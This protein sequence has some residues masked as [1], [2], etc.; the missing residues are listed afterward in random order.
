MCRAIPLCSPGTEDKRKLDVSLAHQ[1]VCTSFHE[2]S[3]KRH[4]PPSHKDKDLMHSK[5]GSA[6]QLILPHLLLNFFFFFCFVFLYLPNGFLAPLLRG[7]SRARSRGLHSSQQA[8]R[9]PQ[10]KGCCNPKCP[11]RSTYCG[12]SCCI[13][14]C[15]TQSLNKFECTQACSLQFSIISLSSLNISLTFFQISFYPPV[16]PPFHP[17]LAPSPP[18]TLPSLQVFTFATQA[19]GQGVCTTCFLSEVPWRRQALLTM[20]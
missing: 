9:Q 12:K 3:F 4:V 13:H 5:V 18:A 16:F 1:W 6:L 8:H 7:H 2:H 20:Q 17:L 10:Q 15:Q 14:Q 19:I 11:V